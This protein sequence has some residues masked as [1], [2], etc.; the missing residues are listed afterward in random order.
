MS[1]NFTDFIEMAKNLLITILHGSTSATKAHQD[2]QIIW[3]DI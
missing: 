3:K 2:H 1:A